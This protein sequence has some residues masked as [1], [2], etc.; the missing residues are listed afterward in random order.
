MVDN[1]LT[2]RLAQASLALFLL[3][4]AFH[5]HWARVKH[6]RDFS[7]GFEELASRVF[8]QKTRPLFQYAVAAPFVA[9]FVTGVVGLFLG[10][11]WARWP[12]AVGSLGILLM[13]LIGWQTV[14][15]RGLWADILVK[16]GYAVGGALALFLFVPFR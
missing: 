8:Q 12:W 4:S 3:I 7:G 15:W 14:I 11:D 10:E 13:D 5:I 6:W 9:A 2:L 1:V 16:L